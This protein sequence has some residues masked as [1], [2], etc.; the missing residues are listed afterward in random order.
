MYIEA[1][2]AVVQLAY[3]RLGTPTVLVIMELVDVGVVNCQ[4]IR[5]CLYSRM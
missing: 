3:V 4:D 2:N 1:G 5:I